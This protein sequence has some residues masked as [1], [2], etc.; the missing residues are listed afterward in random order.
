MSG[1]YTVGGNSDKKTVHTWKNYCLC[2]QI[3]IFEWKGRKFFVQEWRKLYLNEEYEVHK[4]TIDDK[5]LKNWNLNKDIIIF[6]RTYRISYI[7]K[8]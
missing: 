5:W 1:L 8:F 7:K 2:Q 6:H 3:V 4:K